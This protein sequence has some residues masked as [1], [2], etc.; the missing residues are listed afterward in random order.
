M[1]SYELI[2]QEM[3]LEKYLDWHINYVELN[4]KFGR[5]ALNIISESELKSHTTTVQVLNDLEAIFGL[6]EIFKHDHLV[7]CVVNE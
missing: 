4:F 1:N 3:M 5:R 2:T 7:N 6:E